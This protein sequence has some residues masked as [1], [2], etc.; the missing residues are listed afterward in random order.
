MFDL[1]FAFDP[2]L[3]MTFVLAGLIL[4]V[5]PGADFVFV[6][7]S[8]MA[9]GARM[10]IA[11]G[12]G[13]NLGVAVHILA[14]AAGVSALLLA[15]PAAYDAVRYLGAAYLAYLAYQ[16]WRSSDV[17]DAGRAAPSILTAI[18]RG[19]ITNALNPKTALF[20]FAVIPQFT[21]PAIGPIWQQILL[22]GT[23]F[24][25]NGFAFTLC[26]GT[27]AGALSSVLRNHTRTLTRLS[28]LMFAGLALRIALDR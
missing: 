28:S 5:T 6:T 9:G 19:F 22:L 25:I 10:G 2:S 15:Y 11:A 23:I 21:D 16:M 24:L 17:L 12:V 14:A 26:L 3:L 13:I 27:A 4:N 1:L 7:A 18:S 8:G 20:I